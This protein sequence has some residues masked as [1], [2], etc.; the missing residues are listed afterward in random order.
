MGFQISIKGTGHP[1]TVI[2]SL[3]SYFLS[4]VFYTLLFW[5]FAHRDCFYYFIL[6]IFFINFWC[7]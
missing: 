5:A 2:N 3:S 6:F 1:Q 4:L 7:L